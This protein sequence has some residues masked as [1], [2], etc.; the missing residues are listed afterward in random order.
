MKELL[1]ALLIVFA[2]ALFIYLPFALVWALN[3]LFPMLNIPFTFSTWAAAL[4]LI[5]VIGGN[6]AIKYNK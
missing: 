5:F 2:I 3:T 6:G 1:V 4:V